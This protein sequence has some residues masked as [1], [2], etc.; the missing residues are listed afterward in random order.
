[1]DWA[2]SSAIGQF[3]HQTHLSSEYLHDKGMKLT[4]RARYVQN[5]VKH[6]FAQRKKML[7]K[8]KKSSRNDEYV[9]KG[10]LPPLK[11]LYLASWTFSPK[12]L[13]NF[14]STDWGFKCV[15]NGFLGLEFFLNSITLD[16]PSAK[17]NSILN[18]FMNFLKIL[19]I[20]LKFLNFWI[21]W[22]FW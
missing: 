11:I 15:L 9:H 7:A 12:S 19:E 10:V 22:I 21:F 16:F 13:F 4:L 1:M 6:I 5:V 20:L 14:S 17:S 8:W 2:K 18:L 3:L